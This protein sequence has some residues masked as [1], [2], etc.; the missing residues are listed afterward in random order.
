M[1]K[2]LVVGIKDS[3]YR[4]TLYE[5]KNEYNLEDYKKLVYLLELLE[6]FNAPIKKAVEHYLEK[7]HK[8]TKI[9]PI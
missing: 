6:D 3:S 9:F 5:Y 7:K 2:I 1:G 4:N 8:G